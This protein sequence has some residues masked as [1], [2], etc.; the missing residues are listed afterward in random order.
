MRLTDSCLISGAGE[1]IRGTVLGAVDTM[2]KEGPSKNDEIARHG[3]LEMEGGLANIKGR[4]PSHLQPTNAHDSGTYGN[5][6]ADSSAYGGSD[7]ASSLKT[8]K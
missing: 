7:A 1:N 2:T 3:R 6:T 5:R 4:Q 8:G